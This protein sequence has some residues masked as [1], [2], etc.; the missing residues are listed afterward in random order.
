MSFLSSVKMKFLL[1]FLAGIL[2]FT[3]TTI[4]SKSHFSESTRRLEALAEQELNITKHI[5]VVSDIQTRTMQVLEALITDIKNY[6]NSDLTKIELENRIRVKDAYLQDEIERAR[7]QYEQMERAVIPKLEG[8]Q[9]ALLAVKLYKE[10]FYYFY[11]KY[12]SGVDK[13]TNKTITTD[14]IVSS[15]Q[16]FESARLSLEKIMLSYFDE[17][18]TVAG[19][20]QAAVS[21]DQQKAWSL[22]LFS[23]VAFFSILCLTFIYLYYNVL[24]PLKDG[25]RIAKRVARG[26]RNIRFD[27]PEDDEIGQLIM[28][29]K[30]M[31]EKIYEREDALLEE[32]SKVEA[33]STKKSQLMLDVNKEVKKEL[34]IINSAVHK[35][36]E[37]NLSKRN[38]DL[39]EIAESEGQHLESLI[40]SIDQVAKNDIEGSV[41]EYDELPVQDYLLNFARE[42]E[43]NIRDAGM[44]LF[45]SI[46]PSVPQMILTNKERLAQVLSYN[47][48]TI[49]SIAQGGEI[50]LIVDT[51]S[52]AHGK[53]LVISMSEMR[54][55]L[56]TI[57]KEKSTTSLVE[58]H[59]LET[60]DL[61]VHKKLIEQMGGEFDAHEVS[62]H[63]AELNCLIPIWDISEGRKNFGQTN[64][65]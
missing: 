57:N 16:D 12:L 54:T 20:A 42:H 19:N 36:H 52:S 48:K 61:A 30:A 41:E 6:Q 64:V 49:L 5:F 51:L 65:S 25:V 26:D 13:L 22:I 53:F 43:K 34:A 14:S 2:F 9:V 1:T 59:E 23:N 58:K 45:T 40:G 28:S 37:S 35:V 8:A 27:Y 50:R 11:Q 29:L 33:E 32:K 38:K 31:A 10:E 24:S 15:L 39:L 7:V 60:I 46:D 55:T 44:E 17:F 4:L 63:G 3:A 47:L 21:N 56:E 18:D 62:G